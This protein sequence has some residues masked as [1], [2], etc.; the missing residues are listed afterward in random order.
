MWKGECWVLSRGWWGRQ[1][2]GL[3]NCDSSGGATGNGRRAAQTWG[4]LNTK[5]KTI[6]TACRDGAIVQLPVGLEVLHLPQPW[7]RS[8][9]P[10]TVT[11]NSTHVLPSLHA[12]LPRCHPGSR[13]CCTRLAKMSVAAHDRTMDVGLGLFNGVSC[14]AVFLS[15]NNDHRVELVAAEAFRARA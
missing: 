1:A 11:L 12:L 14:Q 2:M 9:L 10:P 15:E 6:L 8:R 13:V 3:R 7:V 4:Y 5:H